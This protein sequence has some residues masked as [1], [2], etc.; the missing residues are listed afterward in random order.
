MY[1]GLIWFRIQANGGPCECDEEP[2]SYEKPR[3]FLE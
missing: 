2:V 1:A 3:E